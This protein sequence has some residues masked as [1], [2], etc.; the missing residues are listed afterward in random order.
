MPKKNDDYYLKGIRDTKFLKDNTK[1]IYLKNLTKAKEIWKTCKPSTDMYKNKCNDKDDSFH[2][3][4]YNPTCYREK[5]Q[6]Y[7][8]TSTGRI[9]NKASDHTLNGLIAP[10]IS[11]F[12]YNQEL[13]EK[14][15]ELFIQW[16]E[17]FKIIR[18][19]IDK[20]YKS[21]APT[22]RQ[23][24]SYISYDEVIKI[25]DNLK[26][27]TF[28]RLLLYMYT[29]I[30]PVRSD[31]Y[32]T[33]IYKKKPSNENADE[34]NYIVMTK[35]PYLVLNKY[36]T[37]KTYKTIVIDFPPDLKKEIEISLEK[38]PR[39]YLF[40]ST[41]D[42]KPYKL[43][44][45]FNKWANRTLK[46]T[47]KNGSFSLITLRHIF[48]SRKDLALHEKTGLEKEIIAAK[49]GHSLGMQDGYRWF[50]ELDE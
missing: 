35:N 45:T 41:R 2:N 43:E 26:P 18:D 1:E 16:K 50:K 40:V 28:P 49:M 17:E 6:N 36:K 39:E 19:P 13:K 14:E 30:P 44:G 21:N 22:E 23:K 46:S 48:I 24:E 9:S 3:I 34:T 7:K 15:S 32:K 25:R 31:Y 47:V 33:K 20:Q 11:I 27:G 5:L 12:M 37:A 4:I 38:Y 10:F 29:A 42:M 8:T